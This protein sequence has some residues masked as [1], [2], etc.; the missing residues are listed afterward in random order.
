ME[1]IQDLVNFLGSY[2]YWAV[3]A[4]VLLTGVVGATA[5]GFFVSL[6]F[7][8]P[9]YVWLLAILADLITDQVYYEVGKYGGRPVFKKMSQIFDWSNRTKEGVQRFF[10][11]HGK[12]SVFVSKFALGTGIITQIMAGLGGMTRK[13]FIL[14][15]IVASAI[16]NIIFIAIGIMAGAAWQAWVERATDVGWFITVV[17]VVFVVAVLISRRMRKH[18]DKYEEK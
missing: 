9:L 17:V 11:R 10:Y 8:N 16:R 18:F 6:G 14:V 4:S 7:F 12:K 15:N 1:L 3:F 5:S 13:T 2:G